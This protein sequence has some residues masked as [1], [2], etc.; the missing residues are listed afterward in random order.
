MSCWIN[1]ASFSG[2]QFYKITMEYIHIEKSVGPYHLIWI[3]A[4][5]TRVLSMKSRIRVKMYLN[6]LSIIHHKR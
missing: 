3:Y 1:V 2:A 6:S 5:F 4:V